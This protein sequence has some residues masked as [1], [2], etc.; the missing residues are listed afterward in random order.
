MQKLERKISIMPTASFGLRPCWKG[1]ALPKTANE[2]GVHL[3]RC[4]A[5]KTDSW[6]HT[7]VAPCD[8]MRAVRCL[9]AA[10]MVEL[11]D[12]SLSLPGSRK[13]VCCRTPQGGW[14]CDCTRLADRRAALGE[15]NLAPA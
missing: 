10:D 2:N 3:L 13:I 1:S 7:V 15:V 11:D 9:C 12:V 14:T 6:L 4:Q 8:G 5:T